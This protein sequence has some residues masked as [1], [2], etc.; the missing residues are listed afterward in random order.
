[1]RES[2]AA[3]DLASFSDDYQAR[4]AHQVLRGLAAVHGGR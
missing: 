2:A 4:V 1:M 3:A